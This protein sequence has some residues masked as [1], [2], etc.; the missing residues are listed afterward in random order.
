MSAFGGSAD[1]AQTSEKGQLCCDAQPNPLFC[2]AVGCSPRSRRN[3]MRRREFIT[4]LVIA[5]SGWPFAGLA[6]TA[7]KV[8]RIGILSTDGPVD[9]QS[10]FDGMLRGLA[11]HGYVSDRNVALEI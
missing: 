7:S 5:I 2:N 9:A 11:S 1:I 4:S 8:Y 3:S 6:Q 10:I